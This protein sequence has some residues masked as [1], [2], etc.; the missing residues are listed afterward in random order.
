[1]HC[2]YLSVSSLCIAIDHVEP[3]TEIQ[4]QQVQWVFGGPQTPS[5]EDDNIVV[6][7]ESPG[8]SN[9]I[10][11]ALFIFLSYF[12]ILDCALDYRSWI[13]VVVILGS[14]FNPPLL[15]LWLEIGR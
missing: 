2:I 5:C 8:A 15:I 1:M 9:H 3:N 14:L 12:T 10:P 7:R 4:V 6:I 13:E 11:W